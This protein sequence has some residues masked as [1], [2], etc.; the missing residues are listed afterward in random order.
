MDKL[1]R[2]PNAVRRRAEDLLSRKAIELMGDSAGVKLPYRGTLTAFLDDSEVIV[3]R[4]KTPSE[5]QALVREA[6]DAGVKLRVGVVRGSDLG[7][8]DR[9]SLRYSNA[10]APEAFMG[11]GV[12]PGALWGLAKQT[13]SQIHGWASENVIRRFHRIYSL[14]KGLA[15]RTTTAESATTW[16]RVAARIE[17]NKVIKG[18]S[19]TEKQ[20]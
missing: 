5:I 12:T 14:D 20:D 9:W 7:V 1:G 15:A 16:G 19:A 10:I 8:L 18:L 4:G 3:A 17:Y 11:S 6:K 2:I 13:Y